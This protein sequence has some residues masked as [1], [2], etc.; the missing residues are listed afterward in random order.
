MFRP[1][2]SLFLLITA[3]VLLLASGCI[4]MDDESG[5]FS[6]CLEGEGQIETSKIEVPPFTGIEIRS[7]IEVIL[8][9]GPVQEVEAKGYPNLLDELILEV[10]GQDLEIRS[11]RCL[12]SGSR[13]QLFIT[14][15]QLDRIV[16]SS[17]ASISSDNTFVITN[18]EA[19]ASG[20]G[21]IDIAVISDVVKANL[22]GSGN[23]RLEG[24]AATLNIKI[25]GSGDFRG[26]G[27]ASLSANAFISGSGDAEAFV[28]DFLEASISGSG[29]VFYKGNPFLEVRLTGT[30]K[31]IDAN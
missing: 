25:T 4:V 11:R 29:D 22:S 20:S 27:L 1:S 6:P 10:D 13:P 24:E 9:Q 8:S 3:A 31:V 15:P 21:D 30:G 5:S 17:M 26:F 7:D 16:N 19:T 2:K 18:L 23:L 14:I 28:Q 12:S